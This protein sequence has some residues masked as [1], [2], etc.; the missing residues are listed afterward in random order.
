MGTK[1]FKAIRSAVYFLLISLGVALPV[2]ANIVHKSVAALLHKVEP[3]LTFEFTDDKTGT[4]TIVESG[5][6]IDFQLDG[7]VFALDGGKECFVGVL[8]YP[9]YQNSKLKN[10]FEN[11]FLEQAHY[12]PII[13]RVLAP[14]SDPEIETRTLDDRALAFFAKQVV[15]DDILGEGR[16]QVAF[17]GISHYGFEKPNEIVSA[18]RIYL[19]DVSSLMMRVSVTT[20]RNLK[21]TEFVLPPDVFT[22]E[23]AFEKK[24][25]T[26]PPRI[27]ITSKDGNTKEYSLAAGNA[28]P[29]PTDTPWIRN[30]AELEKRKLATAPRILRIEL[31]DDMRKPVANARFEGEERG[32]KPDWSEESR[33]VTLTTDAEGRVS[34]SVSREQIFLDIH[35]PGYDKE[36]LRYTR[37]EVPEN[38]VQLTLQPEGVTVPLRTSLSQRPH[39]W[40]ADA[41]AYEIGLQF[42]E[43]ENEYSLGKW[44][45]KKEDADI[46]F[47]AKRTGEVEL[48]DIP[49]EDNSAAWTVTLEGT[50]GW[51]LLEGP[52]TEDW[53]SDMREAPA[54]GYKK[55]VAFVGARDTKNINFYLRWNGGK[56]YG[57][58]TTLRFVD[59]SRVGSIQRVLWTNFILQMEDSGTRS[60]KPK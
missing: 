12:K 19:Y 35:V 9:K 33:H 6:K 59:K 34:Y 17:K 57:A 15:I 54:E 46:W 39:V 52:L 4:A 25:E 30:E 13:F 42:G 49:K 37:A 14:Y 21:S 20:T 28:D 40:K 44:V 26:A 24:T 18:E 56:R 5:E 8:Q 50:N 16:M 53:Q 2:Q 60:L 58:L 3:R 22:Q 27:K 55:T 47:V 10:F 43:N 51:D 11:D 7:L 32:I 48:S 23:V 41:V 36:T 31:L 29:L 45:D 38:E 1:T